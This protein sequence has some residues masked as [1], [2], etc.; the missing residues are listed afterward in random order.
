MS[1]YS[2]RLYKACLPALLPE[3]TTEGVPVAWVGDSPQSAS[4]EVQNAVVVK[5]F[6]ADVV[7][8][9]RPQHRRGGAGQHRGS[10]LRIC[11]RPCCNGC[12]HSSRSSAEP[13]AGSDVGAAAAVGKA[14]L[15]G[16]GIRGDEILGYL[17]K[18]AAWKL[19]YSPFTAAAYRSR[20]Q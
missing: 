15:R 3:M 4:N 5:A 2:A 11:G 1:G 17:V 6:S 12:A 7:R 10:R 19:G 8:T 20:K 16:S 9:V 18:R 14:A 13:S